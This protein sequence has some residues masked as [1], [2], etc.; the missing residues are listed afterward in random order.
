MKLIPLLAPVALT[1]DLPDR[2]L[3]RGQIGTVVEHL[4]REGEHALLVE[5]SDEQGQTYAMADLR[6]DQLIV[7]HRKTEAA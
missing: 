3:T 2:K 6:P 7:L 5:F 4:E 1:E